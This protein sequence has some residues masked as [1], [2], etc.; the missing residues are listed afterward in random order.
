MHADPA[1]ARD[2]ENTM[3]EA[4]EGACARCRAAYLEDAIEVLQWML[5]KYKAIAEAE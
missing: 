1:W 3:E 5:E 4:M 2:L